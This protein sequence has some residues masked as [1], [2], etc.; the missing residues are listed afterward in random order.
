MSF[1]F[2][3]AKREAIPLLLGLAGG[4]GSGKTYSALTLARG[5]AAGQPFAGIDTE[6][7]R[8]LHYAEQFP[9]LQ[10][11]RLDAPFRPE[12][13]AEAIEAAD[14]AG[15][16]VIV[17]D[18]ASHEWAGDGGVIDWQLD[19]HKRLGG[20][21]NVKL[22]SWSTPKQG[23]KRFVTRL[24]QVKAH[25]ILC[26]RAEPKVDMV[27][28]ERTGKN[29]IVP[30]ASLTGLDG[31][32][33][34]TE[35][36]LPFELVASFLLM[37]DRP[38][39]PRP[40]KL[41]EQHRRFVPLDKPLTGETGRALAEWAAGGDTNPEPAAAAAPGLSAAEFRSR[42]EAAGFDGDQVAEA[43]RRLFPGRTIG[44]LTDVEREQL[45]KALHTG[46][47]EE[48]TDAPVPAAAGS[49]EQG[50][51]F[52]EHAAAAQARAKERGE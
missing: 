44:D 8:M 27:K 30:K 45:L 3:P 39:Y 19:E 42:R 16:P 14:K 31:W 15:Y 29:E 50:S 9:E 46:Q 26:F 25:V 17:V 37:A 34:I 5:I 32:L 28:N 10:H 18:S 36:N 12:R 43:G 4:T 47:P 22:L 23:H 52:E 33:P 48:T 41:E 35:K 20:G 38:G 40:I 21:E 6:N 11:A 2:R 51:F 1:T 24:L 13:Y 7:G 49:A